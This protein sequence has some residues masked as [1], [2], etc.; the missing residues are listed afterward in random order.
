[1]TMPMASS[2]LSRP[3]IAGRALG[4]L[5]AVLA[6]ACFGFSL[7]NAAQAAG[8]TGVHGT[9]TVERCSQHSTGG[10]GHRSTTECAGTFRSDDGGVVAE[11]ATVRAALAVGGKVPVQRSGGS[12][13]RTGF[14]EITRR[15]AASFG[16]WLLL[17]IGVPFAVTGVLPRSGG[18]F[19][20]ISHSISG[21]RAA[22]CASGSSWAVWRAGRS[23]CS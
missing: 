8:L 1:M 22:P 6:L 20:L 13:V 14:G 2:S 9:L 19:S 15:I 11:D 7:A 4:A 3:G 16:G 17:A 18:Q 21:T 5:F 10:R 12:Y 23:A